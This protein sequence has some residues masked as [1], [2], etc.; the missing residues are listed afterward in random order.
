MVCYRIIARRYTTKIRGT[1]VIKYRFDRK[2]DMIGFDGYHL[3]CILKSILLIV[4]GIDR[5][6]Q[7][8]SFV[9]AVV[10]KENNDVYNQFISLL[11]RDLN[12][13][14]NSYIHN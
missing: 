5:N 7:M 10:E 8:Y 14:V 13:S 6:N 9:Y 3:S 12:I 2:N 11:V 1:H 4:V